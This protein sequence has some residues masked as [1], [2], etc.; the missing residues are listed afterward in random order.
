MA[1]IDPISKTD[2]PPSVKVAFDRQV[3]EFDACIII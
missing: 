1:R 2:I 3:L